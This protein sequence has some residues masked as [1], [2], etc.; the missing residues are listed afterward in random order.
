MVTMMMRVC[1]A[2]GLGQLFGFALAAALAGNGHDNALGVLKLVNGVLQLTIE[3]R[4]DR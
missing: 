3:T 1:S 4:C 2:Q